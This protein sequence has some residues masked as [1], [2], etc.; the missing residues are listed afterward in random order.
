MIVIAILTTSNETVDKIS[1]DVTEIESG[2]DL[3]FVG[4]LIFGLLAIIAS[5]LA[6][7]LRCCH[8]KKIY[9]CCVGIFLIPVF[10][11]LIAVG[12]GAVYLSNASEEQIEEQCIKLAAETAQTIETEAPSDPAA[13]AAGYSFG[14]IEVSLEIY[15]SIRIDE[16]MCSQECP[17][18]V[19]AKSTEWTG[20]TSTELALSNRSAN[21]FTFQDSSVGQTFETYKACIESETG[22]PSQSEYFK[23]FAKAF[24][25]QG[26]FSDVMEFIEFFESEYQCAGICTEA[27]FSWS[28]SVTQGRPTETCLISIKDDISTVF[29]I[30]GLVTFL[31]GV[32]L[33]CVFVCQYCLWFGKD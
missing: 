9:R 22:S 15:K 26:N 20:L 24:R 29:M 18:P 27:L 13:Q 11:I 31:S 8:K 3:F 7:G 33:L 4:T 17:C 6:I 1:Q 14:D 5:C 16:F 12:G 23:A 25:D 28:V 19:T 21:V 10:L 32:L 2:K 30:L